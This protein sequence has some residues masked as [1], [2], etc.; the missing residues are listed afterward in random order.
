MS[1]S[2]GREH[3]IATPITTMGASARRSPGEGVLEFDV[4]GQAAAK[5]RSTTATLRQCTTS[6]GSRLILTLADYRTVI[7][8]T[9]GS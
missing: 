7:K 9:A 5:K 1:S 6:C 4:P 2:R 8:A 3:Q